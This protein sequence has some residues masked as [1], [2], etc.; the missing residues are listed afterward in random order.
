MN[1]HGRLENTIIHLHYISLK[2]I[3]IKQFKNKKTERIAKHILIRALSLLLIGFFMVNYE[4]IHEES[5]LIGKY[6]WCLLMAFAVA[7]IWMHW[8]KTPISKKWHIYFQI[9]GFAILLFLAI[10]YKG[11]SLGETWMKSHCEGFW[12]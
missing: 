7:L 5:M 2:K 6:T 12:G 3:K 1:P 9:F 11:G 4:S 8:E 10:M